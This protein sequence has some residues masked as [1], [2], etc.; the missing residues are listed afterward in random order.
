LR[1]LQVSAACSFVWC[2]FLS[3]KSRFS[4]LWLPSPP[5]TPKCCVS[6]WFEFPAS[7]CYLLEALTVLFF[8]FAMGFPWTPSLKFLGLRCFAIIVNVLCRFVGPPFF[9]SVWV[10][11]LL[12][13][14]FS[15]VFLKSR[16]ITCRGV[17]GQTVVVFEPFLWFVTFRAPSFYALLVF[18]P[19][20]NPLSKVCLFFFFFFFHFLSH[21]LGRFL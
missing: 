21:P 13:R 10:F 17:R 2:F 5:P 20:F 8:F 14:C 4:R 18:F 16:L 7:Q 6:F 3:C 9:P 19:A 15:G 12:N 11:P 1:A